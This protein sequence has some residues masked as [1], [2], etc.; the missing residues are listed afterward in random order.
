M[1][2]D[3]RWLENMWFG[4]PTIQKIAGNAAWLTI[5]QIL[6][7]GLALVVGVW[8]ARYLGP[9]QY[10]WLN[11]AM[12]LVAMV[13]SLASLGIGAVVVRELVKVPNE[14][15]AWLGTALFLR[16]VSAGIGFLVCVGVAWF[17]PVPA[18]QVRWLIVVVGAGMLIQV[19]DVVDLW[20]QARGESMVSAWVRMGACVGASLLKVVLIVSEAPLLAF[21]AAGLVEIGLSVVGWLWAAQRKGLGVQTWRCERDRMTALMRESWPLALSGIA[22]HVQAYVDQ[23]VIGSLLGGEELGQYA[24]AIRL[25]SVFAFVPTVVLTVAAPEITRAK[26]DDDGLYRKRLHSL[27]RLMV[28]LFVLTAVPLIVLGPAVVKMLYGMPYAGAAALLPWLALR[29]FF[30]NLGVARSAFITNEGLFRFALITSAVGAVVN[31]VLNLLLVPSFG[32]SG[33][34]ISSMASFAVTILGLEAFH[35]R[36]RANLVLMIRAVLLPWRP[37]SR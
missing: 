12:A 5:D 30:T 17:L 16:S 7:M 1:P 35:S 3:R 27:Y 26:R 23:L 6:R 11:Y 21:A 13:G 9:E 25:V 19:L 31:V 29:L 22:I 28:G 37:Y 18:D 24:A 10:G 20:F 14:T 36:A 32:A 34:I 2:L 4:R 8:I 33:A 15:E